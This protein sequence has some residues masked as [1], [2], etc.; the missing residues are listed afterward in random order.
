VFK[1]EKSRAIDVNNVDDQLIIRNQ[2]LALCI[3]INQLRLHEKATKKSKDLMN[4]L[5]LQLLELRL[6]KPGL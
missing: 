6:L 1:S 2:L 4:C 5:E 3:C